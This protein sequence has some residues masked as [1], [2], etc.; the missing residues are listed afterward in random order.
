MAGWQEEALAGERTAG[1]LKGH[2]GEIEDETRIGLPFLP[3]LQFPEPLSSSL[4]RLIPLAET[5]P[6]LLIPIR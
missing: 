2:S 6:N 1:P 4:K 3:L 5:E